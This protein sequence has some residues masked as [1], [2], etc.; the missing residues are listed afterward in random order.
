LTCGVG[1]VAAAPQSPVTLE[2][3]LGALPGPSDTASVVR[4]QVRPPLLYE[5]IVVL[6]APAGM[7][8]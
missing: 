3:T 4:V 7:S 6:V 8:P 1:G 2:V 5:T